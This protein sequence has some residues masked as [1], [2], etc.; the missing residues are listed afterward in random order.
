MK[1]IK[2]NPM[3]RVLL[4]RLFS[5]WT[6]CLCGSVCFAADPKKPAKVTYDDNVLPLLR[7]KCIACHGPDK[8][9][10][11]LQLHNYQ[12]V[13]QGGSGGAVVKPGDPD[14]SELYLVVAHKA[15]PFM[16]PKSPPLA[17]DFADTLHAWIAGGALEN[18]G[19]KAVAMKPKVDVSLTSVKR[20]KPEGPP[21]MPPNTLPLDPIVRTARANAVTALAA[22]PWS[23]LVAVGGQKQVLLYNSDTLD[24]IGV[25]P[26]P[27]G[28]PHVLKFSRNGALLLAG[29]GHDGKSGKVIV[30]SVTTGERVIAVGEE[31]DAVLAADISPDQSQIAL[32]GPSKMIRLFSTK[33]GKMVNEIKKHTDW[34]TAIEYSPDGV[35]LATGDRNGGLFVWEAYTAREY[36][37]LR[38]HTASITDVSWRADGNVLAS[39]SEDTTVRLWEMENGGQIKNWG[40]HGGGAECV[41]YGH[42]GRLVSAGRDRAVKVWDG[43]GGQQRQFELLPD[44]ALR[45]AFTHDGGRV[46]GGDWTG[47][48]KVWVTADGRYVGNLSA[49]PLTLAERINAATQ[50]LF[51]RQVAREQLAS[52]AAGTQAAVQKAN[53]DLAA[54]QKTA[55]E[56]AAQAKV[57]QDNAAKAK[58]AVDKAKATR[59]AA[60]AEAQARQVQAQAF[61]EAAAKVKDA[62]DKSNGNA[63][64]TAAANR[65]Q[66]VASQAVAE[67]ATA[68]RVATEQANV[69]KNAEASLA[70]AQQAA[71]AAAAAASAAPK[72]VEAL[73]AAV[74]AAEAKATADRAA[75]EAAAKAHTE[76]AATVERLK[77]M[78]PAMAQSGKP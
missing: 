20:G 54:A 62:A 56:R 74:H 29:G 58:E 48:L 35:L 3:N 38:G 55:A 72:N 11:G 57:A 28:V 37:S 10:S 34:V 76:T 1:P 24:L 44:V 19:S 32:G 15:E 41:C 12:A 49:N 65:T 23:P 68:Q 25:L 63:A 77:A 9:S 45:A 53:A 33:D 22:N 73:T 52:L 40:A 27:E 64:M 46:V 43:N 5:L 8:K 31:T 69:L 21:P 2:G 71:T 70:T 13:M 42:D 66:S 36:F 18:S 78:R 50:E 26:F 4:L 47:A 16:P 75:A 17:S 14:G 7:D 67:A 59:V 39:A 61:V 60:D 51:A 30:W 6:L